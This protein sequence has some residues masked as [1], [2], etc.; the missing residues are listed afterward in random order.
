MKINLST[1]PVLAL[2][3]VIVSFVASCHSSAPAPQTSSSAPTKKWEFSTGPLPQA[4]RGDYYE[5]QSPAIGAD[6][7]IYAP[8]ASGLYAVRPDG[9][10][11]WFYK[12]QYQSPHFPLHHALID[13]NGDIWFDVTAEVDRLIG[14]AM[15]VGPDGREKPNAVSRDRVSQLGESYDGDV[16]VGM[17]GSI[18]PINIAG[19][20]A[21][22]K[23]HI[24][25][26][27]FSFAQDGTI[28]AVQSHGLIA[29]APNFNV[30]WQQD[31]DAG[32]EPALTGDGTIVVGGNGG[33]FALNPD[34]SK[35]WSFSLPSHLLASPAIAN[36]GTLYFGSDDDN[37]YALGP[38]GKLRW[39][40]STG[41]KI[42]STP[43]IAKN[44]TVF[45]GAA[46]HNLYALS[47]SGTLKWK[48]PTGGQV[49]SPA[50]GADGTIYFQNS[51]G[52]LFALDDPLDNGELTGQWPK[53]GA[54]LRN[55][56]RGLH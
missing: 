7:T 30:L 34:G 19:K 56:N 14:G 38:D 54:G 48:F 15:Q 12:P 41:D 5:D 6:G 27:G 16:F 32:G 20:G 21:D 3:A 37:L 35:K 40:F 47:A 28:Y 53:R 24:P 45:L 42:T 1:A 33:L 11:K 52:K 9:T 23:A 55:T 43:A 17:G 51:E 26:Y 44:G 22:L 29:Y 25:G 50:I 13:D 4:P 39:K 36:D 2:L 8:G 46:D 18:V 31:V 10:Q 49:F